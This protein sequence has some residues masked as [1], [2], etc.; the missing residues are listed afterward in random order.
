MTGGDDIKVVAVDLGGTHLRVAVVDQAG[1][2]SDRR[3]QRTPRDAPHPDLLVELVKEVVTDSGATQA[4][5]GVPGPVDYREGKMRWAPN[6]PQ[7][8]LDGLAEGPL[9]SGRRSGGGAGQ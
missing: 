1:A 7:S 5:V 2:V 6:L 9:K 4:V 3:L 8:W